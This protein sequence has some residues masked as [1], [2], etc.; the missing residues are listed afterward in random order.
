MM[1]IFVPLVGTPARSW[2]N[3]AVQYHPLALVS[4]NIKISAAASLGITCH[5]IPPNPFRKLTIEIFLM[6]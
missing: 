6:L 1:Q 3:Y 5:E 2:R 4:T